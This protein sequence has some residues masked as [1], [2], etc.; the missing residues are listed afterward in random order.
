MI[1]M[2]F[3]KLVVVISIE[4]TVLLG[5]ILDRFKNGYG[6]FRGAWKRA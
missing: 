3:R 5:L 4:S 2:G 1:L 6:L